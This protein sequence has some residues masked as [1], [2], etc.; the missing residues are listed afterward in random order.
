MSV[1]ETGRLLMRPFTMDDLEE[2]H[3]VL[4]THPDVWRYDPGYAPSLERREFLLRF[5]VLEYLMQGFGCLALILKEN[6]RMIGYCGLQL[7][8]WEHPP[9]STPEV[10][11]F[12]KLGR[13]YWGQGYA[14]EAARAIIDFAFNK[15][16]I[17][18]IVS[19]ANGENAASVALMRRVGMRI[20][21]DP[22]QPDKVNG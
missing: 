14:T 21:D 19:Q 5:R 11:L 12:Y 3:A 16:K 13:E 22:L 9:Q 1:L 18:R 6:Q 7:Y 10:E 8:L 2:A 4:D 17:K 15:L 20:Q